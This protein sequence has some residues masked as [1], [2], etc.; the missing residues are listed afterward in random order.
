MLKSKNDQ[1]SWGEKV[2]ISELPGR[3]CPIK[4]L[5][6]NLAKFKIPLD[7][8]DL[9]SIAASKGKDSLSR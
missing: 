8:T 3:A 2:V 6:K 5:K 7:S 1:L 9:I 4:L